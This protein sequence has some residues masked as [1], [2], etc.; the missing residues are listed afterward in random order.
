M[1]FELESS[2]WPIGQ[3]VVA[4]TTVGGGPRWLAGCQ[5]DIARGQAGRPAPTGGSLRSVVALVA[6]H[7]S[8]VKAG[9]TTAFVLRGYRRLRMAWLPV[10]VSGRG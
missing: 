2:T 8:L 6:T 3:S 4:S 9:Q 7:T 1:G 5:S 10:S